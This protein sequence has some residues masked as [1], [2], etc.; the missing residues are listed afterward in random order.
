MNVVTPIERQRDPD[1]G[2]QRQDARSGEVDLLA[3]GRDL[4]VERAHETYAAATTNVIPNMNMQIAHTISPVRMFLR[5]RRRV[6]IG[7]RRILQ[8]DVG[9]HRAE[10]QREVGERV[11]VQ[12][13]R[14][15]AIGPPVQAHRPGDE[16]D[17]RAASEA[18]R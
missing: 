7:G 18:T 5:A 6:I 8:M 2:Q 4:G 13:Q 10:Q 12:A 16:A 11:Q 1:R 14:R 15:A 3:D 9:D 17:A